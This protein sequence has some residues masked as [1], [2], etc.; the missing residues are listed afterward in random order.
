MQTPTKNGNAHRDLK[1]E[2]HCNALAEVIIA[3]RPVYSSAQASQKALIETM[4][5]AAIWYVPKPTDAWTGCIS[6]VALRAFHPASGVLNPK[7]SEEHVYPRKVAAQLLL[8]DQ[9][10]DGK[11]MVQ[12]FTEKY[13]RLHY[14]TSDEN[15]SVQPFQRAGVFTTPE[16]AYTKAGIELIEVGKADLRLIKQRHRETIEKYLPK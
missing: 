6:M 11:R 4:I 9:E 1:L 7:F 2:K 3:V 16:D 15:K 14:I 12:L 10:L 8:E 5:G 13:G